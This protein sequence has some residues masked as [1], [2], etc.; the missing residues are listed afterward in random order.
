[1]AIPG[2]VVN[3]GK[4]ATPGGPPGPMGLNGLDGSPVGT[5]MSFPSVTPPNGWFLCDGSLK[6]RTS[7]TD[8]FAVIGTTFGVGD[9][10]TTFAL[11]DCRGKFIL[12]AGLD[13]G[14]PALTNRVLAAE[15]GAETVALTT[16]NLSAHTHTM[17][18]HTHAGGNHTHTMGNHTHLGV[19]HLH[20]CLGVNHL[21][22]LGGHTHTYQTMGGG[23][24]WP[25][26]T[27]WTLVTGNTGG[28]STASDAADRSLQTNTGAADRGL[29]TGG[30]ST[31]TSDGATASTSGGP[32]TNTSDSTGSGTAHN[33]M[34]PFLVLTYV[35]KYGVGDYVNGVPGPVGP[36]GPQGPIGLTGADS[37]VPGPVGPK[38]DKGDTGP[39]GIQGIQGI[40]GVQGAGVVIYNSIGNPS[41]EVDQRAVGAGVA[42]TGF[43]VDRWQWVNSVATGKSSAIPQNVASGL[44]IPGTNLAITSKFLRLQSTTAQATLAAAEAVYLTQ[45]IEGSRMRELI[46]DVHSL[47]MLVRSNVAGLKF[48]VCI[49]TSGPASI[50]G[51]SKLCTIQNAN[52]WALFTFPAIPIWNASATWSLAPGTSGYSIFITVAAGTNFI[53]SA[54][55]VW[56]NTNTIG[57]IGQSNLLAAVGNQLDVAFVQHEPGP[58]CNQFQ[59]VPYE[60]NLDSC[61]RYYTKSYRSTIAGRNCRFHWIECFYWS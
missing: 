43:P 35:I 2:S 15:G 3:V 53:P 24:T 39:Q 45:V 57:A 42:T 25:G 10:S 11:P 38:G 46:G 54:N 30:P 19:D 34:P 17:G 22:G 26:S 36:Q 4:L 37:T 12:G 48:G 50:W 5:V 13:P 7:Y 41:L 40:Q 32:S 29:T 21:H 8:L 6:S 56:V 51:L 33:N 59:D 44:I 58:N 20:G 9:G 47:S 55:D 28:P 23:A 49:R 18:N 31:N 1:M 60:Q 52:Q 61:L 27:G 16:A 14:P